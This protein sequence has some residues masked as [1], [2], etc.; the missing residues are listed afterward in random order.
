MI[1]EHLATL[2]IIRRTLEDRFEQPEQALAHLVEAVRAEPDPVGGLPRC[3]VAQV[4][5]VVVLE[6]VEQECALVV[7][8][9]A[10]FLPQRSGGLL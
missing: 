6:V 9:D 7:V 1:L 2:G 3:D 4:L 10:K 8:F 5:A